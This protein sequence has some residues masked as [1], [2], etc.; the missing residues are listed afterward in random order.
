[1]LSIN[2]SDELV[3]GKI[4]TVSRIDGNDIYVAFNIAGTDRT[5][6][7]K[8]FVFTKFDPVEK[9]TMLREHSTH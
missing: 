1:M 2:L 5:V 3:N 4:G 7:I 8:K 6:N 9:R